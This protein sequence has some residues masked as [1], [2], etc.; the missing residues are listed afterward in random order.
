MIKENMV[1]GMKL[2]FNENIACDS[3]A[4]SKIS[5]KQFSKASENRAK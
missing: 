3:C 5:V 1:K 4:K 2:H